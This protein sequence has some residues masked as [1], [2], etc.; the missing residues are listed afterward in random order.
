MHGQRGRAVSQYVYLEKWLP[1]PPSFIFLAANP[2][3]DP[4]QSDALTPAPNQRPPL[5]P[6]YGASCSSSWVFCRD[7]AGEG[8][9]YW[10]LLSERIHY[11]KIHSDTAFQQ[12]HPHPQSLYISNG[13]QSNNMRHIEAFIPTTDYTS[14]AFINNTLNTS[15]EKK[16]K[17]QKI[18]TRDSVSVLALSS[19]ANTGSSHQ[20][21]RR[22]NRLTRRHRCL[23]I[24]NTRNSSTDTNTFTVVWLYLNKKKHSHRSSISSGQLS[25]RAR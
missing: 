24:L 17:S 25:P 2:D 5:L 7:C 9:Y 3:L 6:L 8:C 14:H 1:W 23:Y 21:K 15:N 11:I 4:A 19:T 16:T 20:N 10:W 12:T 22:F 13:G 18:K